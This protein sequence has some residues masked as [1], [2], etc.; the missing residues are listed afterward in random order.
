VHPPIAVASGEA[1]TCAG[2]TGT[3]RAP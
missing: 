3:R 2:T 1:E